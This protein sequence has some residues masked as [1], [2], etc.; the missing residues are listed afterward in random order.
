M[1]QLPFEVTRIWSSGL[2]SRLGKLRDLELATEFAEREAPKHFSNDNRNGWTVVKQGKKTV[3][4]HG[5]LPLIKTGR[6]K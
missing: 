6:G 3:S 1:N 4:I 5:I 2:K